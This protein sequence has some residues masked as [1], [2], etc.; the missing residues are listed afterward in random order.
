MFTLCEFFEGIVNQIKKYLFLKSS[1]PLSLHDQTIDS[2]KTV[3]LTLPTTTLFL[4]IEISGIISFKSDVFL[5]GQCL[6]F[7]NQMK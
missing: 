5:L 3:I 6:I 4:I 2:F 1:F 7:N